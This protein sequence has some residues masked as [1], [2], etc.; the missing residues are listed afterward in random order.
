[1]DD[2]KYVIRKFL[3][4]TNL[5]FV[6]KVRTSRETMDDFIN[7]DTLSLLTV[8]EEREVCCTIKHLICSLGDNS[9]AL[10]IAPHDDQNSGL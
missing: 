10:T 8:N 1:M 6:N 3:L 7:Q 2:T 9:K 5:L 4:A